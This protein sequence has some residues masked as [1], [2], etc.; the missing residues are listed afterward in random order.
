MYLLGCAIHKTAPPL[1][2]D[3]E[4]LRCEGEKLETNAD[5]DSTVNRTVV[6][7]ALYSD[8]VDSF[9]SFLMIGPGTNE[10][11]STM[12]QDNTVLRTED[13]DNNSNSTGWDIYVRSTFKVGKNG[14]KTQHLVIDKI[15]G[16]M[17][18]TRQESSNPV[19]TIRI[20]A[21]CTSHVVPTP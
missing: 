13:I 4:Y 6:N 7:F 5:Q 16:Q 9:S 8:S 17:R 2:A 1:R 20:N 18:F 3:G 19:K 14:F 15:S 21:L 10:R 12:P 11:I